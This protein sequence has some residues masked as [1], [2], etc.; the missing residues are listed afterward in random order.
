[1][2]ADSEV[3]VSEQRKLY[4]RKPIRIHDARSLPGSRTPS[5]DEEGFGLV[6]SS[7]ELDYR[8]LDAVITSFYEHCVS[9]I[10]DTTG[11]IE[12]K[13]LEHQFRDGVGDGPVGKGHYATTVHADFSPYIEEVTDVPK[14]RH[15]GLF[16][17]WRSID[18]E[19]EI[20]VMPLAVCDRRTVLAEDIVYSDARRLTAHGARLIDCRLIHDVAHG[21]YYFPRMT[22][23]EVLIFRQYDTR[24]EQAALRATFHTAFEDPNTR[25]GAPLRRTIE[26]RVMAVF[27]DK[28]PDPK[29]RKARFQ[30]QVPNVRPD[31]TITDWHQEHMSDWGSGND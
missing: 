24:Y 18:F 12:A 14:D 17:I 31:G 6:V 7:V 27:A 4:L 28:D 16:N 15:F 23:D 26:A 2:P 5:L 1:M 8:N 10:K 13:V 19:Q 29:S 25:D 22:A 30:A 20:E 21:W 3:S 9:I 11:C